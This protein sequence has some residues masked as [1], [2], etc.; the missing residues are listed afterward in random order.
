[1]LMG[2]AFNSLVLATVTQ[3][4]ETRMLT[5]WPPERV[6]AYKEYMRTTSPCIPWFKAAP[7]NKT[8]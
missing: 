2:T 3:M 8:D 6:A 1:M 4:T 5:R 7:R